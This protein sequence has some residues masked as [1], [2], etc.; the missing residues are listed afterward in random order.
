MSK[1]KQQSEV[2]Q[3]AAVNSRPGVTED[4]AP[5]ANI[6]GTSAAESGSVAAAANFGTGETK[7]LDTLDQQFLRK[8]QDAITYQGRKIDLSKF[9]IRSLKELVGYPGGSYVN[10]TVVFTHQMTNKVLRSDAFLA[11][12]GDFYVLLNE[13]ESIS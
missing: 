3:I 11:G 12:R 6:S 5:Q 13:L 2:E 7:A 8:L 10:W 1:T 4:V 9:N